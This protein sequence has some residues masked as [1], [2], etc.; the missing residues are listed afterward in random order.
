LAQSAYNLTVQ[1]FVTGKGDLTN[2]IQVQRQLLDYNLKTAEAIA[3]YNT[4][5]ANIQ[6]LISSKNE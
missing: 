6:K 3:A 1:E 5:V 4:M 2:V